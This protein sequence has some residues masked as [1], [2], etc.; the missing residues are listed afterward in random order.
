MH[1]PSLLFLAAALALAP[2]LAR[3]AVNHHALTPVPPVAVPLPEGK[4]VPAGWPAFAVGADPVPLRRDGPAVPGPAWLRVT[5]ALDDR[6]PRQVEVRLGGGGRVLGVLDLR[7]AHAIETFQLVLPAD[8]AAAVARDGVV[9]R[10]LGSGAPLW[11][12]GRAAGGSA[13]PALPVEFQPHLMTATGVPDRREEFRRRFGS[14]ASLQTFGWMQGCVFDGLHDLGAGR[15]GERFRR[16]AVEHW[17]VFQ[18]RPG[19][20][21]YESPRS[22]PVDGRIYGIEGGLPFADLARREPASPLLDR[23]L[24]FTRQRTRPHGAIQDSETLSAEGSYTIGYPLAVIAATRRDRELG[25][26]ALTQLRV[27]RDRLWHGGALWLRCTDRDVRT[28]RGWARGVAWHAL[29]VARSIPPLREL[30]VDTTE[31]D[32]ELRR[33]AA[34]V[35]PL[36]R[37]DGLWACFLED[38]EPGRSDTS[39]S[40]G[41]AASLALGHRAGVLPAAAADAARRTLPALEAHLTPDG[42]LD[43]A[44]QSNRGGEALQRSDYRVLSQMGMGLMAQ[45]LAAE[46]GP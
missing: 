41:I 22:A 21:V 25:A 29:G 18:P 36:Q 30:G 13:G 9:L 16:A 28:F 4:R 44:A 7:F 17:R 6:E 14:L 1:T 15:D 2:C 35:L 46:P 37:K 45:L 26:Q 34:W 43:G 32:Q 8:A 19:H 5:T 3:A 27:R 42:L 10:L 33:L 24:E 11:F 40:A 31:L 12:F 39:G 20:L 38:G 23:F